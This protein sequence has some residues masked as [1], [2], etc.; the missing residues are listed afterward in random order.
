MRFVELNYR[1]RLRVYRIAAERADVKVALD[2][3]DRQKALRMWMMIGPFHV[4]SAG[5][6]MSCTVAFICE[7]GFVKFYTNE[8]LHSMQMNVPDVIART[9]GMNVSSWRTCEQQPLRGA[10]Q[11]LFKLLEEETFE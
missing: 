4:H 11:D 1:R 7:I 8:H 2:D 5:V 10:G 9:Y 3:D 6:I